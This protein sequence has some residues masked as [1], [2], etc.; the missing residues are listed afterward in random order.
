M[1][2]SLLIRIGVL[3]AAG[4]WGVQAGEAPSAGAGPWSIKKIVRCEDAQPGAGDKT[5]DAA[6]SKYLHVEIATPAARGDLKLHQF[7]VVDGHGKVVAEVYGFHKGRSTLV[8]DGDWSRME[9]LYLEGA[10][11]RE[12]LIPSPPARQTIEPQPNRPPSPTGPEPAVVIPRRPSRPA[13]SAKLEGVEPVADGKLYQEVQVSQN[14]R[15]NIQG[16]DFASDLQYRVL[17]GLTIEKRNAD[18]S[19]SVVQKVEE[20]EVIKADPLTQ[21]VIRDLLGKLVG[22]TFQIS[23][24]PDGRVAAFKG[25]TGGVHA[26]A[27]GNPLAGQSFQMASIIDPDGWREIAELTFFRPPPT[28]EGGQTWDRPM[29]HSWGPLGSW[30][31]KVIFA[32]TEPEDTLER[33]SYTFKLVHQAPKPGSDGL[34]FQIV[35]ADFKHQQAGGTIVFNSA[36]GRV[37]QADE[38][39]PVKGNL[40]IGLLGQESPLDLDETQAFRIRISDTRLSPVER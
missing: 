12:P 25:A 28:S 39:F 10:G 13:M 1:R 31:G 21:S 19:M 35:R 15:M 33:F 34:P 18:G 3:V 38:R 2:R 36:K 6:S 37:V 16:M 26:A 9:G 17:S 23:V 14:S 32:R 8:F 22:A 5:A 27:G 7:T 20:A 40:T 24:G 4:A 30:S 29:T 11:H